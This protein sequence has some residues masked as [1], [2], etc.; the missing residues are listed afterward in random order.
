MVVATSKCAR[1][2]FSTTAC[3][4]VSAC[5]ALL[6]RS[7]SL[8]ADSTL[9]VKSTIHCEADIP[10]SVCEAER[11]GPLTATFVVS[12]IQLS[13]ERLLEHTVHSARRKDCQAN[14]VAMR[15]FVSGPMIY[16]FCLWDS[17]V[18][19]FQCGSLALGLNLSLQGSG[20]LKKIASL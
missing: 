15:G 2:L 6:I 5:C 16:T 1:L 4:F 8:F 20:I 13:Q 12:K 19:C 10:A 3:C 14:R 17:F 18:V 9:A 7:N 11:N